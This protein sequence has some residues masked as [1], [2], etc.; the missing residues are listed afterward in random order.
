MKTKKTK[1]IVGSSDNQVKYTAEVKIL[2]QVYKG[3]GNSV[4]EAIENLD[5]KNCKGSGLL[6][7]SDGKR[8][9]ERLVTRFV[10][11]RIFNQSRVSREIGLK[12]L[13]SIFL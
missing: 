3:F 8:K 13:S 1:K 9:Q 6:S 10:F 2:G 11:N 5:I 7:V 4:S 12:Q